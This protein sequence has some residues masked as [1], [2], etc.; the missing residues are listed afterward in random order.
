MAT[1]QMSAE[2]VAIAAQAV[3][4]K[5]EKIRADRDK[6][7][8]E[9]AISKMMPSKIAQWFGAK[10]KTIEQIKQIITRSW[11]KDYYNYPSRYGWR[12]YDY[13]KRLLIIAQHGDPVTLTDKDTEVLF[14]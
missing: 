10:P 4:D 5:I 11:D 1:I 13:A 6:R 9:T 3:I 12:E 14:G 2:K 7:T 8:L